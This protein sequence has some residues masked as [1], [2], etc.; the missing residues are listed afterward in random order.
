[1]IPDKGKK[2]SFGMEDLRDLQKELLFR[3]LRA[4]RT[5][6]PT[7]PQNYKPRGSGYDSS[8]NPLAWRTVPTSLQASVFNGGLMMA[9]HIPKSDM[10]QWLQGKPLPVTDY[11][12]MLD[13][14]TYCWIRVPELVRVYPVTPKSQRWA[15]NPAHGTNLFVHRT[16]PHSMHEVVEELSPG[17]LK[18]AKSVRGTMQE[19][20]V[21][22]SD[23]MLRILGTM[24]LLDWSNNGSTMG[25]KSRWTNNELWTDELFHLWVLQYAKTRNLCKVQVGNVKDQPNF[26]LRDMHDV[27]ISQQLVAVDEDA[28][29]V[30]LTAFA[31]APEEEE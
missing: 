5:D 12:W 21:M 24:G 23:P 29:H 17:A 18:D 16:D 14:T 31:A 27:H 13:A 30:W 2:R 10:S 4:I 28:P 19:R 3:E 7:G 6:I 11:V 8:Q 26:R 20:H 15:L 22:S 25:G 9:A 1:M